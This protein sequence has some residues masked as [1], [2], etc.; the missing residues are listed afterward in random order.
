MAPPALA[1]P[2]G[3]KPAK[4]VSFAPELL[5]QLK[6]EWEH[7]QKRAVNLRL[8]RALAVFA[9]GVVVARNFG[10]ALFVA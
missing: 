1:A 7:P 6:D 4:K 9:A 10:E 2:G 5:A 8:L 3:K